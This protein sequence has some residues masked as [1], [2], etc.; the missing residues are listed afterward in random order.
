[1]RVDAEILVKVAKIHYG[2]TCKYELRDLLAGHVHKHPHMTGTQIT[3]IDF[4]KTY[5]I[6]RISVQENIE[7]Q[8]LFNYI[9][10]PLVNWLAETHVVREIAIFQVQSF[11][12]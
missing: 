3:V 11:D 7:F 9:L 10:P 2:V 8:E 4:Y 5:F 6:V 12:Y 1:M